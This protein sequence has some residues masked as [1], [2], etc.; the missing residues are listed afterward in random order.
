MNGTTPVLIGPV[1]DVPL[2]EA[3]PEAGVAARVTAGATAGAIGGAITADAIGKLIAVVNAAVGAG[4]PAIKPTAEFEVMKATCGT[5]TAVLRTDV[6]MHMLWIWP[7]L[8]WLTMLVAPE[9][10]QGIVT[11]VKIDTVVCGGDDVSC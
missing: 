2:P 11:V 9:E 6:V 1:K 4:V 7:S 3:K 5:A 10:G 8:I